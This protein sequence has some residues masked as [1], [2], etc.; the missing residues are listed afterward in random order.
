[1]AGFV[2]ELLTTLKPILQSD[3]HMSGVRPELAVGAFTSAC[4]FSTRK[5]TVLM[6]P[7]NTC[8]DTEHDPGYDNVSF[9]AVSG[10][11]TLLIN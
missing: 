2:T 8:V 3:A 9:P 6:E 1:M 10:C 7:A 5:R 4:P 11:S